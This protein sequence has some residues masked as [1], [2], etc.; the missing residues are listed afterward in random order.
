MVTDN[1][2]DGDVVLL[3]DYQGFTTREIGQLLGIPYQTVI[4][5]LKKAHTI[6][7]LE[8]RGGAPE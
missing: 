3:H 5:R 2:R 1:V 4:S 8:L 6:L 7:Q